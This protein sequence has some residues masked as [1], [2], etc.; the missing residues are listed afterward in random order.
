MEEQTLSA[1]LKA[2]RKGQCITIIDSKSSVGLHPHTWPK[3][4]CDTVTH[5]VACTFGFPFI[6]KVRCV[7][8]CK[9]GDNFGALPPKATKAWASG[10]NIPFLTGLDIINALQGGAKS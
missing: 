2:L 4:G 9:D 7:M 10:K 6:G 3:W 1:T 5:E 8:L